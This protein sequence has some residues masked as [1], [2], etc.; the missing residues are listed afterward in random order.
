[1]DYCL[2]YLSSS[3]G[4]FSEKE[5]SDILKQSQANN[6]ALGITGV[7]LYCNGSII[8]V[9]EGDRQQVEALYQVISKDSR[10]INLICLY[11]DTIQ[12]RSFPDWLMGYRT[13]TTREF[14]Q[15][16]EIMPF[17]Q[18]PLLPKTETKGIVMALVQTFY[19]NNY[20]N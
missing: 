16:Y 17:I 10:H 5:I 13:L 3:A 7:L 1:M 9:L 8:Q 4:L 11:A 14:D 12:N 18:D 2:V 6:R 20:R 15:L 19:K